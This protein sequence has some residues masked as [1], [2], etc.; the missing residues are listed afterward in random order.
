MD[1]LLKYKTSLIVGSLLTVLV[2]GLTLFHQSVVANFQGN[3]KSVWMEGSGLDVE[4]SELDLDIFNGVGHLKTMTLS[5][6]DATYKRLI[7]LENVVFSFDPFSAYWA[8]IKVNTFVNA[9]GDVSA[10]IIGT[11]GRLKSL[12]TRLRKEAESPKSS[13]SKFIEFNEVNLGAGIMKIGDAAL[14]SEDSRIAEFPNT[15][16]TFTADQNKKFTD[17]DEVRHIL[18]ALTAQSLEA[19]SYPIIK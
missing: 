6:R 14:G 10:N 3:F 8:P 1:L 13:D 7:S 19:T 2:M 17:V 4:I 11:G 15:K 16:I 18:I 9:D 5:D 12:N